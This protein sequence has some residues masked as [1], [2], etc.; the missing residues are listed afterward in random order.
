LRHLLAEIRDVAL[1]KGRAF[2]AE[3]RGD[4]IGNGGDLGVGRLAPK[5]GIDSAP[6][7]VG[8]FVP[9]IT[10]CATLVAAGS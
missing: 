6:A 9:E 4:L 5:A 1:G 3:P 7:G 8:R 10:I 2:A